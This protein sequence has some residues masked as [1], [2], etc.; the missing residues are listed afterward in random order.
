[1]YWVLIY[2][3]VN[4]MFIFCSHIYFIHISLFIYISICKEMKA[5]ACLGAH[6]LQ[7]S[8]IPCVCSINIF[9]PHFN[10]IFWPNIIQSA[11]IYVSLFN[12]ASKQK[13]PPIQY[14]VHN[15]VHI[16]HSEIYINNNKLVKPCVCTPASHMVKDSL[17]HTY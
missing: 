11:N 2:S 9:F 15:Q 5:L 12:L 10:V 6:Q 7:N 16:G 14:H 1:M 4:H 17:F 3:S 13:F 8:Y